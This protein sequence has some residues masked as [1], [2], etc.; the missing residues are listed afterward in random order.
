[1]RAFLVLPQG[2]GRLGVRRWADCRL[3]HHGRPNPRPVGRLASATGS[4]IYN[5]FYGCSRPVAPLFQ[6]CL[7]AAVC[8]F[9]PRPLHGR[10]PSWQSLCACGS[11]VS[12]AARQASPRAMLCAPCISMCSCGRLGQP[13][14]P[15]A[16]A[17]PFPAPAGW[18][19]G[20]TSSGSPSWAWRAWRWPST[21]WATSCSPSPSPSTCPWRQPRVPRRA[22]RRGE[23]TA[24][25]RF[26]G[27]VA[28]GG[29]Q[30]SLHLPPAPRPPCKF[31]TFR[32]H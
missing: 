12:L 24:A 17:P 7:T 5:L 26:A 14:Q 20:P 9:Q 6:P 21:P 1:M 2:A 29:L 32:S 23:R 13:M 4:I 15:S 8:S 22:S 18:A 31:C 11:P 19:L 28:R 3:H 10:L 25:A 27:V 30:N 16:P